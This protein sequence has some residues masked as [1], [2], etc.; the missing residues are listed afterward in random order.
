MC[1]WPAPTSSNLDMISLLQVDASVRLQNGD[2]AKRDRRLHQR[3]H[4]HGKMFQ[5]AAFF[6]CHAFQR[7][8]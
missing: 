5:M 4:E 1:A 3:I 7:F 8:A 2:G 6:E